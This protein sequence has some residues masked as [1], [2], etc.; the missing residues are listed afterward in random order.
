LLGR[1]EALRLDRAHQRN[2]SLMSLM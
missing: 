2:R 1:G